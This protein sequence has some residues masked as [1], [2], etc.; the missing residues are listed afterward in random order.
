MEQNSKS[1]FGDAREPV[2]GRPSAPGISGVCAALAAL[3]WFGF[4]LSPG[5]AFGP[6]QGP[7]LDPDPIQRLPL[8]SHWVSLTASHVC[9]GNPGWR[10]NVAS[11]FFGALSCGAL[12]AIGAAVAKR[13]ASPIEATVCGFAAAVV[14]AMTPVVTYAGTGAGPSMLSLFLGLATIGLLTASIERI[15]HS[16]LLYAAAL[17]AG[18]AACNHA[19]FGLL[20]GIVI[21]ALLLFGSMTRRTARVAAIALL[22]FLAASSIPLAYAFA[23]SESLREFLSHALM[24]PYPNLFDDVP[25]LDFVRELSQ[26]LPLVA[27]L[28]AIPGIILLFRPESR[29]YAILFVAIVLCMGPLLPA[30]TNQNGRGYGLRDDAAP[31]M[32]AL[33][34]VC[35]CV[36]WGMVNIAQLL[37]RTPRRA[38]AKAA[39]IAGMTAVM[40]ALH[41]PHAPMRNHG[42]AETLGER[43]LA[44]CPEETLLIS[45]DPEITS[46]LM[47]TQ[48]VGGHRSDVT[49]VPAASFAQSHYARRLLQRRLAGKAVLSE[50]FPPEDAGES[51]PKEQPLLFARFLKERAGHVPGTASLVDLALWDFIKANYTRC[52][53]CFVGVLS[54]WLTARARVSGLVLSYP[55]LYPA[56]PIEPDAEFG[57]ITADYSFYSLDPGVARTLTALP[58]P[59]AQAARGQGQCEESLRLAELAAKLSPESAAPHLALLRTEARRGKKQAAMEHMADY[60]RRASPEVDMDELRGLIERDLLCCTQERDFQALLERERQGV[61]DIETR[62]EAASYLWQADELAVL[63]RGYD[64][65][66]TAF[67]DDVDA[68]YQLAAAYTQLGDLHRASD[69]LA[70]WIETSGLPPVTVAERLHNDGRFALLRTYTSGN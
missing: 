47:A 65:V 34:I 48:E 68:L 27:L 3:I 66:L 26:N 69:T 50:S 70:R 54:P 38:V 61:R 55:R 2:K 42:L 63:A 11:A 22:L 19:A 7:L 14:F 32:L 25:H 57:Q 39:L 9:I 58:I 37:F 20:G 52:P 35:L 49:V 41:W 28:G 5:V 24:Q 8:L 31:L 45:G 21:F 43:I 67:P 1:G 59:L 40:A 51:W 56:V 33:A 15:E 10:L 62:Q 60:L 36:A 53:L 16:L 4:R 44:G 23:T 18:I 64:Y 46:L 29:R 13:F 30:L 6:W 17:L 12:A